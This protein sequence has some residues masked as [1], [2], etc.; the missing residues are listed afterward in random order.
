MNRRTVNKV[1]GVMCTSVVLFG[2]AAGAGAGSE[3][4]PE[5]VDQSG[6]ANHLHPA[7]DPDPTTPGSVGAVDLV[8]IWFTTRYV[9]VKDRDE[10]G[11]VVRV[12]NVSDALVLSVQTA[13]V[14]R[15][16]FLGGYQ[17]G[18]VV[19]ARGLDG[20][21]LTL[22]ASVDPD[23]GAPSA[24]Q[25][26]GCHTGPP[27]EVALSGVTFSGT[28]MKM[29][30]PL[31]DAPFLGPGVT[32]QPG[33]ATDPVSARAHWLGNQAAD[34]AVGGRAFTV[35]SDVPPDIDCTVTPDH[36]DCA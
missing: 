9:T 3:P 28:T 10:T 16:A 18:Y 15:V 30:I 31:A 17:L 4:D 32:I 19:V 20:C 34:V 26:A 27:V 29:T 35:G 36:P 13:G 14:K 1:L 6:D 7:P 2:T 12:R 11:K 25:V 21:A 24:A 33:A 22:Y 23:T 8:K 5:I